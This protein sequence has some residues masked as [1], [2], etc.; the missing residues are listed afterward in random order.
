MTLRA[1]VVDDEPLAIERM[2]SL[3]ARIPEV[4]V[5]GTAETG[6][7][8]LAAVAAGGIDLLFLDVEMPQLDG[9]DL[10]EQLMRRGEAMPHIVLVTAHEAHA[11]M[12]FDCGVLDFL[13]KPVRLGRLETAV[14]RA[15]HAM[16]QSYAA[17]QL[18]Q[19]SEQLDVLRQSF[20]RRTSD[21]MWVQRRGESI[22]IDLAEIIRVQAEGEY[23]RLFVDGVDYL[24][25]ESLTAMMTRL[26]ADRFLRIHRSSAIDRDAIVSV[27]RR[28]TG[29]YQVVLRDG[30]MLPVGRTYRQAVRSVMAERGD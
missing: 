1:L 22:R 4:D 7:E 18:T 9:F 3:L 29:N 5:A 21:Y 26:D 12:A 11:P 16:H 20:D 10:I 27:R 24:H 6:D 14:A 8:A 25:R 28:T 2:Q 17:G 13:T 30:A 19:V 15:T 23:V